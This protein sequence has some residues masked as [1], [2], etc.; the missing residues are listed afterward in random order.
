LA[1]G[2]HDPEHAPP[3]HTLAH[4]VPSTQLPLSSQV[5]GM[6]PL[7]WRVPGV[8]PPVQAP[9]VHK[10]GHVSTRV[11]LTRSIPQRSTSVPRQ[12]VVPGDTPL[13]SGTSGWQEPA[14]PPG[15]VSQ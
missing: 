10:Y 15:V 12:N 7:H 5:W 13:H 8:H 14:L 2:V 9:S 11:V 1:F 4:A 3:L 6:K